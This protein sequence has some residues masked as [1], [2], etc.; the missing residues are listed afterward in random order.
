MN[1]KSICARLLFLVCILVLTHAALVNA[2]GQ[3]PRAVASDDELKVMLGNKVILDHDRDGFMRVH[4]IVYAP[5]SKHFVVI[6][7]GYE[8]T[9]NIGFLFRAD[10]TRKREF[11]ARWDVIFDDKLE[12]STDGTKLY[13]FRINSTGADPPRNAPPETWV[14]LNVATGK[15][16]PATTRRLD[17][18]ASYSVFNTSDGLVVRAQPGVKAKEVGRLASDAKNITVTGAGKLSGRAIW[19]PIRHN[20]LS[21]WVNQNFLF[22]DKTTP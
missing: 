16:G 12:W 21:G 2:H 20:E 18:S 1:H 13:Y 14:V 6:G 9:D 22:K 10:G 19:V 17:Q 8:C 15:K 3:P 7:C 5:S 11:T 4:R